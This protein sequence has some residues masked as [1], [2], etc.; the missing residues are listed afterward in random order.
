MS[1]W[2]SFYPL[3]RP[4]HLS[5]PPLIAGQTVSWKFL[6][7]VRT[8]PDVVCHLPVGGFATLEF[9]MSDERIEILM[10]SG[11]EAM[12]ECLSEMDLN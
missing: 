12:R 7:I 3:K 8:H 10:N 9:D 5:R 11:R 2:L 1:K 6:L 4:I